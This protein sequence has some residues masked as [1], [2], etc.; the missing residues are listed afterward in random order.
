PPSLCRLSLHDALPISTDAMV[1]ACA[2]QQA[3]L[4]EPWPAETLLRVRMALNT[5]AAELR[6][7]DYYGPGVNRC[8]RL[9]TVAH[10]SQVLLSETDRKS[11]RLNSSHVAS[12]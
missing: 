1:A 2:L 7:G 9:R 12:S 11:T 10:G 4:A 6:E 5:A 3:L 8:A